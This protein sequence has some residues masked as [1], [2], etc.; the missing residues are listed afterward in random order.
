MLVG[1]S[2]GRAERPTATLVEL[3]TLGEAAGKCTVVHG[4]Q[5]PYPAAPKGEA[6]QISGSY[7]E[8][9]Q[10]ERPRYGYRER[11]LCIFTAALSPLALGAALPWV[12]TV[13]AA[14]LWWTTAE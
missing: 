11:K 9:G 4:K 8:R 12:G 13:T 7:Q 5:R 6:G 1:P 10:L 14:A 3:T 2:F